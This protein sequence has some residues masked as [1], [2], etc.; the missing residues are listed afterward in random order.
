MGCNP[1]WSSV[2]GDSSG[3]N[4]EWL[5]CSPPEDLPNP[6]IEPR[7]SAPQAD[8][9]P[10]EA[11]GKPTTY[12][13][14]T[15]MSV[16]ISPQPYSSRDGPQSLLSLPL[17]QPE[18][19]PP[20]QEPAKK[21]IRT[22]VDWHVAWPITS[23]KHKARRGAFP[24]ALWL[25]GAVRAAVA[26]AWGPCPCASVEAGN[27]AFWAVGSEG[28]VRNCDPWEKQT[29]PRELCR[30]EIAAGPGV[31][32]LGQVQ[33][34][35]WN[36]AG[37]EVEAAAGKWLFVRP[38]ERWG[39]FGLGRPCG[40]PRPWRDHRGRRLPVP[41]GGFMWPGFNPLGAGGVAGERGQDGK[42]QAVW[43]APSVVRARS[44]I[45]DGS[46]VTDSS[47]GPSGRTWHAP[48]HSAVTFSVSLFPL[49][50]KFIS[51]SLLIGFL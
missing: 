30:A 33:W 35:L 43:A 26:A 42:D 12:L 8:S 32:S 37:T 29:G 34:G 14:D 16:S 3:R 49:C 23:R 39:G 27:R 9:L 28:E 17:R 40:E 47:P 2:H 19:E 38:L 15:K 1:P 50:F 44:P 11:R 21:L 22:P 20:S 18:V 46:S 5:P 7:S 48:S 51:N 10:P 6:G 24:R 45:P 4:M 25:D 31:W 13:M 41:G 36:R